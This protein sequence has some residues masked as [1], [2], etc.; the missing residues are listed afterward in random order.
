VNP[1]EKRLR[2]N[3]ITLKSYYRNRTSILLRMKKYRE[4]HKSQISK[5]KKEFYKENK[6]KICQHAKEHR[7]NLRTEIKNVLG[8][9]CIICGEKPKRLCFHDVTLKPHINSPRYILEHIKDF[10][11]LCYQCHR[12][13]H[14]FLRFKV[15]FSMWLGSCQIPRKEEREE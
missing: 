3:A 2:H 8:T 9:K 13:L 14:R 7:D 4:I 12:T 5:E 6:T 15:A 1:E 10:I 11:P